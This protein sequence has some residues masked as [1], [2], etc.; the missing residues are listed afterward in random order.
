[1]NANLRFTRFGEIRLEDLVGTDEVYESK[2]VTGLTKLG[3]SFDYPDNQNA[4]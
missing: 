3:F 1:L 2:I 4:T